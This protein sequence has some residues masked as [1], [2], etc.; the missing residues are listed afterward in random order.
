MIDGWKPDLNPPDPESVSSTRFDFLELGDPLAEAQFEADLWADGCQI[1]EYRFRLDQKRRALVRDAL[2]NVIDEFDG[3][4]S[5]IAQ[6]ATDLEPH[7]ALGKRPA[8]QQLRSLVNQIEVLLGSSVP[9][10][11]G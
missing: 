11:S 9:R 2:L 7:T 6:S 4:L 3:C 1:S 5:T 10:P 8:W